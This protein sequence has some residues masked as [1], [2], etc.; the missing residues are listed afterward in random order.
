[1]R[2]KNSGVGD[3]RIV[4]VILAALNDQNG[5]R[6]IGFG[7]TTSKNTTSSATYSY[8]TTVKTNSWED[9]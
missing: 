6:R 3:S 1:M 9:R 2:K 4:K 5:Q 8:V 7:Q